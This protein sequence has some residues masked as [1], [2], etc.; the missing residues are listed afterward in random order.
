M[1]TFEIILIVL[2]TPIALA[3]II[4]AVKGKFIIRIEKDITNTEKKELDPI[5]LEIAKRNLE[6][7]EKYNN[8]ETLNQ[9]KTLDAVRSMTESIQELFEVNNDE[10]TK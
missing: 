9:E 7:L 3:F 6:E 4:L 2:L 5:Q 1:T 10:T 8:T